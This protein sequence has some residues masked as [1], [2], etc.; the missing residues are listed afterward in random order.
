MVCVNSQKRRNVA[1][2]LA[3]GVGK[4]FGGSEPK[5]F[6]KFAGKT[7]VEHCIDAFEVHRSIDEIVVVV[8]PHFISRMEGFKSQNNWKKVTKFLLGGETRADSSLVA[9][10]AFQGLKNINLVFHDAVRPL[11]SQRIIT[12]VCEA[13]CHYKAVDVV[14]P[15]VDTLVSV[16]NDGQFIHN[17]PNR[18]D[19][20][21]GQTPQAFYLEVIQKAYEIALK[22]PMFVT[23]DDCG[24][25]VKY[26]PSEPVYLVLGEESNMK[27]TNPEDSYFLEKLFQIKATSPRNE[28]FSAFK[29]K[30]MVVFGGNSGIGYD[31]VRLARDSGAKVYV[32]SRSTTGTDVG[33]LTNVKEALSKVYDKEG[34]IDFVVNSAAVLKRG[35]MIDLPIETVESMVQINYNGAVNT[36]IASYPYLIKSKGQILQFTSSSYTRGRAG[37][38][39]YSSTKCAVV[40]FVQAIAEEWHDMGIRINCINPQRTKTA[41]RIANFGVEDD[42]TLLKSEDVAYVSLKT[43]LNS[44]SGQVIDIKVK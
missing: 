19:L 37:Y 29:D 6:L 11:V 4:R 26:L 14:V 31:M 16:V 17:I 2:I 23:T 30:V 20:R 33:I 18:N 43:L 39:I 27:L 22:D 34:V 28:D 44:F 35:A 32:F 9:I 25:V 40:N 1:V 7:V 5:Q 24:V 36:T 38:A 21:R 8:H 13:L 12:D 42:K 41:M 3:G 10:R 15:A